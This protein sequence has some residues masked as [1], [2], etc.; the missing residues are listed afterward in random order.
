MPDLARVQ[1]DDMQLAG[2]ARRV[3]VRGVPGEHGERAAIRAL[4]QL[5]DVLVT[6]SVHHT[7]LAGIEVQ[8]P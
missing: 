1:V 3:E 8:Q 5:D 6:E 4:H 7:E 2:E